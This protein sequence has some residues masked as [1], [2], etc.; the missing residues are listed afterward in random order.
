MSEEEIREVIKQAIE[1]CGATSM[2]NMGQVMK[3]VMPKV[4]GRAEGKHVNELVK[5]ALSTE[6]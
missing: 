4:K 5:A 6:E 3:L 2:K 1:E